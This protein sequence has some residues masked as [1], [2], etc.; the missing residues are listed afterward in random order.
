MGKTNYK[1]SWWLLMQYSVVLLLTT[2]IWGIDFTTKSSYIAPVQ[3]LDS[4]K[5]EADKH[6]ASGNFQLQQNSLLTAKTKFQQAIKLYQEINDREGQVNCWVGL[7][8]VDYSLGNYRGAQDKLRTAT[9]LGDNRNGRLL[10]LRG[11]ISLELG[12]YRGAL[13]D[14]RNGVHYL[15]VSGSRDRSL[16][17]TLNEARIA[18][19]ETYSYLGQYQQASNKLHSAIAATTDLHLRRRALNALGTV[20]LE[21]GQYRQAFNIYQQAANLPNTSGDRLG[22][23]KLLS[24]LGRAYRAVDNKKQALKHYQLALEE[25]RAIGAWSQQVFV[26]N[27]LGQLALDLGLKNRALEYLTAAEGRL[28]STGGV[29]RVVTLNNL[30]YYY[31]QQQDYKRATK[32]LEQALAWARS[33]GDSAG[34]AKALS[35]LGE[36]NLQSQNYPQAEAALSSS[37]E[38]FESLRPGLRDEDKIALLETQYYTYGLLQQAYVASDRPAQA[39]I[40]AER[41]R[42][43]AFIELLAQ[44]MSFKPNLEAQIEIPTLSE[45]QNVA[46]KRQAT[47]V[48]Y[49]IIRDRDNRESNLY[50]WVVNPQGEI[51]LRQLDLAAIEA[52]YKTSLASVSSN[53][54]Q[55]ASG[56]LDLR[57]PRLE[58]FVVSFRGEI[59]SPDPL[60][61]RRNFSFPRDAYKLLIEPIAD[62]LPENPEQPVIFIPQGELFLVPFPALQNPDGKF[63]IE[64]Y[65]LQVAPSIQ[66]LSLKESSQILNTEPALIVGNPSP[67]PESLLPL[68]GAEAEA[69]NIAEILRTPVLSGAA[70]TETAVTQQMAD[71]KLIHLATHGLFD[72]QQGL[73]SSLAFASSEEESGFLTAEEILDL[74]LDA[75]L[76][77]LSACNTGRG[78]ITGDGV[79]GLSRSFLLAGASSTLVSLWYIPDESTA[80]LMTEFYRNLQDNPNKAQSLRQAMMTMMKE[81]SHPR[82]WA[83]FILVGQ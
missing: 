72:D 76:V 17:Q 18:L 63:L 37:I 38:I 61:H 64:Q 15:Q 69:K 6:L 82:H 20:N 31:A 52:T 11:L 77:V 9:R 83:G 62:L 44:R 47:L 8:R 28:S 7:A 48:T 2:W 3:A 32:Y 54:R 24:N 60:L 30:G 19:G 16:M 66:T 10:S 33:N 21:I 59:V 74:K 34:E 49:S 67:M 13:G 70:A 5:T 79:I 41:S 35:V 57:Q 73:Q 23:A 4:R 25:F 51:T 53:A 36:I 1:L 40:A 68:P 42:A 29:G 58:D 65:T 12:D 14:L 71:A 78:K 80:N 81:N 56:G 26:L 43:R 46:K 27:N 22:K 39:L 55:A 50:I 75:D 45:I